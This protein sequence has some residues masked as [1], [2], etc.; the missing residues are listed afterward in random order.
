LNLFPQKGENMPQ[1]LGILLNDPAE[2]VASHAQGLAANAVFLAIAQLNLLDYLDAGPIGA[3]EIAENAG[4]HGDGTSRVLRFLVSHQILDCDREG[5]FSHTPRS[6]ALQ[7]L[8]SGLLRFLREDLGAAQGL[9]QS[10]RTGIPAFDSHFGKPVFQYLAENPDATEYFGAL[11][12]QNTASFEAFLFANHRFEPFGSAVDVG[13]NRGA[14]LT[15][16]LIEYPT[17][18]GIVFDLPEIAHQAAAILEKSPVAER[19]GAIGGD[20]FDAV[21]AGGD[22]YLL[23]HILHDWNDEE[24][25]RILRSI[26]AAIADGGRLAVI[27]FVLPEA[28]IH[29]RGF[30]LDILMLVHTGGRERRLSEFQRLFAQAGFRFDRITENPRGHSVLEAVAA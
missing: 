10:L 8:Q 29:H 3:A 21:P 5:R 17:A 9:A 22:L 24:C 16:M 20:F 11:M 2:F 28:D 25:M 23:K 18:R 19:I 14:L 13:G 27:E 6:Q 30:T 7:R 4:L 26:R 1:A 15:K 12:A